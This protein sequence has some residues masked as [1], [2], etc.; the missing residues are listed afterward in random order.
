MSKCQ[1]DAHLDRSLT[2]STFSKYHATSA[3]THSRLLLGIRVV[4]STPKN[5]STSTRSRAEKI[6]G[7]KGSGNTVEC[8]GSAYGSTPCVAMILLV[9]R[10]ARELSSRGTAHIYHPRHNATTVAELSSSVYAERNRPIEEPSVH[11]KDL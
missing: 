10:N 1:S 11:A 8:R 9:I 3:R 4:V 7:G 5:L 2:S 6:M